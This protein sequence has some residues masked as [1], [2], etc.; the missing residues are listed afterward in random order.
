[1]NRDGVNEIMTL[2]GDDRIREVYVFEWDG[3]A[4][5]ALNM[6]SGN[7]SG[8]LGP[9]SWPYAQDTNGSS[10]MDLVL[11]QGIPIWSEYTDG[12]PWRKETRTCTWDGS[13]F[14]L[15]RTEITTPPEYR[16]QAVQDGD[17]ASLAGD[18]PKAL[19]LYQQAVFSDTLQAWSFDR[20]L[21][22]GELPNQNSPGAPTLMPLPTPDPAEYP[23]LAAYARYR[24][25]LLYSLRGDLTDAKTVYDTLQAKFPAG[26]VGHAD[27]ELATAFWTSYQASHSIAQ[28][29]AQAIADAAQH[30]VEVLA[31]LGRSD[32]SQTPFG[33][34]SLEYTPQDICPYH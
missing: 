17:R 20:F 13:A 32:Y 16:F 18:Y 19:D 15:T 2:D 10:T 24:I 7:C 30:P 12:L 5:Q 8:L 9:E 4:F 6:S 26:Q 31:Y 21:Y 22:E 27:A 11:K 34:Q 14:V 23:S 29:C 28:A 3:S 1:M 25:L 33:D